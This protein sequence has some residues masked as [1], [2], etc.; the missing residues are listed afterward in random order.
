MGLW[1]RVSDKRKQKKTDGKQD[2]EI[3]Q[4]RE[5]VEKAEKASQE[6]QSRRRDDVG[7]N[8]ERSGMMIQRQYDEGYGRLGKRFAQGDSMSTSLPLQSTICVCTERRY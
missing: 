5:R 7:D 3:K 1:D 4:L 8:F 6:A 2:T